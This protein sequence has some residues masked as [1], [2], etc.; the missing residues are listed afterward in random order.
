MIVRASDSGKPEPLTT[1][2]EVR[3]KLYDA[4]HSKPEWVPNELH[5]PASVQKPENV[6]VSVSRMR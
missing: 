5:C 1:D 4:S 3:I 6:P 2:V